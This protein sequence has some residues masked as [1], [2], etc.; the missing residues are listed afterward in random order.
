MW[1]FTPLHLECHV[2][3]DWPFLRFILTIMVALRICEL[4]RNIVQTDLYLDSAG[5][6]QNLSSGGHSRPSRLWWLFGLHFHPNNS[7][8]LH[9]LKKTCW[10]NFLADRTLTNPRLG[11]EKMITEGTIFFKKRN[12]KFSFLCKKLSLGEFIW[13]HSNFKISNCK[14]QIRLLN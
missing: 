6:E 5:G 8:I 13:I 7:L 4:S 1:K 3:F 14:V 12:L 9:E 2:L 11:S 10:N